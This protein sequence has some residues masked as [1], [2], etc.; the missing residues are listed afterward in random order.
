MMPKKS[1]LGRFI[2]RTSSKEYNHR[3]LLLNVEIDS[4]NHFYFQLFN[5]GNKVFEGRSRISLSKELSASIKEYIDEISPLADNFDDRALLAIQSKLSQFTDDFLPKSI[6][7]YLIKN[8]SIYY[9]LVIE[10]ES[11]PIN[12]PYG[13]LFF[14]DRSVKKCISTKGFFLSEFFT[15]V[16]SKMSSESELTVKKVLTL[17]SDDLDG[18]KKEEEELFAYF[19]SK[20]PGLAEKIDDKNHFQSLIDRYNPNCFHFCCHGTENCEIATIKNGNIEL[21]EMD[22]FNLHRFP[23]N[24][25][26][27]LNI[28]LSAYT[29]YDHTIPRSIA[30]KF[31]DRNANLVVMTEWPIDDSF[32]YII[33]TE[34]YKRVLDNE[35]AVQAIHN[36]KTKAVTPIDKL[37]AITYSLRG[38][39]NLKI[40]LN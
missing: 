1:I 8:K 24:T 22:F 13:I 16:R 9:Y 11:I 12:I 7:D 4:T 6:S 36:I 3:S 30:S 19:N 17:S 35:T 20:K 38:N 23:D 2:T 26:I 32:A 37:T 40:V 10:D 21:I 33:G 27:Y 28:C 39:P 25:F 18:S 31:L 5:G 14:P 29:K 34:F 15:V